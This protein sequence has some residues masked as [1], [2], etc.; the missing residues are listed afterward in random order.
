MVANAEIGAEA[1]DRH[2]REQHAPIALEVHRR[3][4]LLSAGSDTQI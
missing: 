1:A 3:D 2:W 4:V